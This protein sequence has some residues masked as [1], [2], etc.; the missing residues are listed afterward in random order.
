MIWSAYLIHVPADGS[1]FFHCIAKALEL[2]RDTLDKKFI[3]M[4]NSYMLSY[5]YSTGQITND[6]IDESVCASHGFDAGLIRYI[7]ATNVTSD[8][9][10]LY[11]A[12]QA[13]DES[14][15]VASKK[16][17]INFIMT[18]DKFADFVEIKI[19]STVG[20]KDQ[21]G[22]FVFDSCIEGSIVSLPSEW[23]RNKRYNIILLRRNEH[24]YLIETSKRNRK[25]GTVINSKLAT[26]FIKEFI[27]S[28]EYAQSD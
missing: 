19:L 18:E 9:L 17:L 13:A 5:L 20:F 15:T 6:Q 10:E 21:L 25:I 14:E 23:T 11:N 22:I 28:I 16:D 1:C 24:Y 4:M 12:I 3:K 7:C 2:H 8:D 27:E 26:E